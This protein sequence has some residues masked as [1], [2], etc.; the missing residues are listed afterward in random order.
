MAIL[1]NEVK[2]YLKC[3]KGEKKGGDLC[4]GIVVRKNPNNN[5]RK[6]TNG[7]KGGPKEA[8]GGEKNRLESFC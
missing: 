3:E 1:S 7:T 8:S 6:Q 5:K 2:N 4:G